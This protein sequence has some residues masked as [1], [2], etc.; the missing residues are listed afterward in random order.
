[1]ALGDAGGGVGGA[2]CAAEGEDEPVRS[3]DAVGVVDAAPDA[4]PGATGDEAVAETGDGAEGLG[5]AWPPTGP[6]ATVLG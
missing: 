3:G 4:V 1:M 6:S 5:L 2:D